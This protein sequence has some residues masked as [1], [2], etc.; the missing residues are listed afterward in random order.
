[1]NELLEYLAAG[2]IDN[3]KLLALIEPLC[4]D[5]GILGGMKRTTRIRDIHVCYQ[6]FKLLSDEDKVKYTNLLRP[7]QPKPQ[8][9]VVEE[10]TIK[11]GVP[12]KQQIPKGKEEAITHR[13]S[14][15]N[16]AAILANKLYDCKTDTERKAIRNKIMELESEMRLCKQVANG[17]ELKPK[18]HVLDFV[19]THEEIKAMSKAE[20]IAYKN[21]L[22]QK[23]TRAKANL[24]ATPTHKNAPKWQAILDAIEGL[25]SI[26]L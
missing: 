1:M 26:L 10:R 17:E 18:K 15:G 21:L 13:T 5:K 4:R 25:Y 2:E 11:P 7:S 22:A 14:L 19:K 6:T 3:A 12:K 8:Q 16:Q 23:K 24:A 20:I 9:K